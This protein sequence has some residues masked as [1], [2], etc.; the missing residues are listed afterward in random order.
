MVMIMMMIMMMMYR[1]SKALDYIY[2][3]IEKTRGAQTDAIR[4]S[5]NNR[6]ENP[7]TVMKR[8]VIF[9]FAAPINKILLQTAH[10]EPGAQI[11]SSKTDRD[12]KSAI[13][14]SRLLRHRNICTIDFPLSRPGSLNIN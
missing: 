6:E 4:K 1:S 9:F 8:P 3:S 5:T 14:K 12:D 7:R 13:F 10:F 2:R 11:W